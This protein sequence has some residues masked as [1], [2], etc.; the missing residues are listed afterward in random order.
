MSSILLA[1]LSLARL[2]ILENG[3]LDMVSTAARLSDE[4]KS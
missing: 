2:G 1:Q 3:K 4:S